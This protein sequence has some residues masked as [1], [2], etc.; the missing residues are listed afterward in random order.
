MAEQFNIIAEQNESTVVARY[1]RSVRT[2]Q[3]YQ[4]EDNLERA[5]IKQLESQGYEYANWI[6]EEKDLLANLR[7]QLE[8]LNGISLSDTEWNRLMNE[9]SNEQLGIK[10]KAYVIQKSEIVSLK[11]DNGDSKNIR[12]ID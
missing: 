9:I 6:H 3:G 5:F 7:K 8:K 1:E 11:L 12:L 4:S 2:A 10:E